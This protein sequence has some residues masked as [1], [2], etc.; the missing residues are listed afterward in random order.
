MAVLVEGGNLICMSGVGLGTVVWLRLG[1][2]D[3]KTW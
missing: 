3:P 1:L 2:N